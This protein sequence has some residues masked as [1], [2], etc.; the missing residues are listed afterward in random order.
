[1]LKQAIPDIT[2]LMPIYN[3]GEFLTKAIKSIQNQS[4]GNLELL[5]LIDCSDDGSLEVSR[6]AAMQDRRIK[7]SC[8]KGLGEAG[9]MNLGLNL[10]TARVIAVAHADD[11][12]D[13][14]RLKLQYGKYLNL[15]S[16]HIISS[17]VDYIDVKDQV[18]SFGT[19][20]SGDITNLLE[21]E[22]PVC[23][24]TVVYDKQLII[25][26]GGYTDALGPAIDIELWLRLKRLGVR[27]FSFQGSLVKYRVHQS[28]NSGRRLSDMY[29]SERMIRTEHLRFKTS[30]SGVSRKPDFQRNISDWVIQ[31]H[32]R[33]VEPS[34]INYLLRLTLRSGRL[35]LLRLMPKKEIIEIVLL[36]RGTTI[37]AR[38]AL[39]F[40]LS[41][42]LLRK[43][44][45]KI[46]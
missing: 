45:Q 16:N 23:H 36:S 31:R 10:A 6:E 41:A 21:E 3:A 7:V 13:S 2:V 17:N 1:M 11:L 26:S 34:T 24:P 14:N 38:L 5:C 8:N 28:Q 35:E 19:Y 20:N 39:I 4:L 12:N 40:G 18:T 9:Q 25:K 33:L 32:Y 15:G 30:N 27:F 22:N 44:I 37:R 43:F 42:L 46:A 29:L